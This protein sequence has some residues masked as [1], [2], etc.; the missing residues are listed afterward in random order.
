VDRNAV[1]FRLAPGDISAIRFGISPGHELAHAVRVLARPHEHPLQW[2]WFRAV[3]ARVP[4]PAFDL[5]R[6]VVG[7]SGFLPD[8]FSPAASWDVTPASEFER[9]R[10]TSTD[11]ARVDLEKRAARSRGAQ[12]SAL[13]ALAGTPASALAAIADAAEEF[14]GSTLAPYWPQLER[15]LRA[16]VAV[17]AQRMSAYGLADMIGALHSSVSWAG[18]A[19]RV[20]LRLHSEVIDC[21]GSGLVLAP[22]VMAA[23]CGAVTEPPA[24]PTIYY[25]AHNVSLSWASSGPTAEHAL[26]ELLGAGR[27][28]LLLSLDEPLTTSEAARTAGL[29]VSTASHHLAVLA[30]SRLVDRRR[31][32]TRVLHSRS[33]LAQALID[34]LL[35]AP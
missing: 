35:A 26:S 34:D 4:Q 12:Q 27:A 17:R 3:G 28:Q 10:R 9:L 7:E 33:P 25:P 30:R 13:R 31:V 15:L 6:L 11:A 21:A 32:G 29:A 24:Q 16:D 14:W 23:H 20:T 5:L 18:D 1:E 2:G 8:F 19:V 22:T